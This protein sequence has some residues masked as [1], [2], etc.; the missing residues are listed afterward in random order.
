LLRPSPLRTVRTTCTVHGSS[1]LPG[2]YAA[3]DCAHAGWPRASRR[4]S[5]QSASLVRLQGSA[6]N[7]SFDVQSSPRPSGGSP[8][9]RQPPFGVGICP[10]HPVMASRRLSA[11]WR[12]LLRPSSS[13]WRL[14]PSLRRIYWPEPDA[15]GVITFRT[16]EMRVGWVSSLLR[17]LVSAHEKAAI[18]ASCPMIAVLGTHRSGD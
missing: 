16:A 17:G 9:R 3:S 10:I 5:S 11:W 6:S 7:L 13:H 18:L 2:R 4:S 15:I 14:V 8:G 12:S 1:K